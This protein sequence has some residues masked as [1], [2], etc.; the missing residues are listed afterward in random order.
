MKNRW[1]KI[2]GVVIGVYSGLY[3][4]LLNNSSRKTSPSYL[5]RKNPNHC[6]PQK[7]HRQFYSIC[8]YFL[9]P[10]V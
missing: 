6:I 5:I 8:E 7:P 3:S 9:M 1:S 2:D 10:S 4:S